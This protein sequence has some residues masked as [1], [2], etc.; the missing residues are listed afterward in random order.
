MAHD[1]SGRRCSNTS[2]R[3][4]KRWT[5]GGVGEG[6]EAYFRRQLEA[7][8]ETFSGDFVKSYGEKLIAN[9][10]FLNDIGYRYERAFRWN[11]MVYRPDFT[12]LHEASRSPSWST[13]DEP[14]TRTTTNSRR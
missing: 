12:I 10:L 14:V 13:S 11:E 8:L 7:P 4:G 3:N 9:T 5:G 2:P 6:R 1:S